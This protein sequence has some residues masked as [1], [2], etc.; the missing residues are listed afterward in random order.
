MWTYPHIAVQ[1]PHRYSY[2]VDAARCHV[3][4]NAEKYHERRGIMPRIS[5]YPLN[6]PAQQPRAF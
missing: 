4:M 2:A 5:K 1:F 3:V 6:I